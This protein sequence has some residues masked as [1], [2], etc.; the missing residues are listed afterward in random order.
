MEESRECL[1]CTK[2]ELTKEQELFIQEQMNRLMD[3]DR[4]L[5]SSKTLAILESCLN[6]FVLDNKMRIKISDQLMDLANEAG[7]SGYVNGFR[8]GMRIYRIIATM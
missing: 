8:D 5:Y 1:T 4:E 3:K 6:E 2:T 7:E